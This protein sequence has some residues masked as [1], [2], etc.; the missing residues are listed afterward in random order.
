MAVMGMVIYLRPLR[1]NFFE[2]TDRAKLFSRRGEVLA[3]EKKAILESIEEGVLTCD[4]EGRITYLNSHAQTLLKLQNTS[5]LSKKLDEVAASVESQLF[6]EMQRL[7][8]RA[9]AEGERTRSLIALEKDGKVSLEMLAVPYAEGHGTCIVLRDRSNQKRMVE[10]G[11]EFIANA[12]HELRTP[13][14]IIRGFAETLQDLQEISEEMFNSILGKIIRNCE[15]MEILVKNLLTLA[16]L[17]ASSSLSMKECDLLSVVGSACYT[18]LNL[19]PKTHI[20]QLQ[21]VDEAPILADGS[22]LELA[23]FNLLKNAVKYSPPPAQIKITILAS[24]E[25]VEV[26]IEDQG[27]GIPE[28]EVSKIFDRFY[29]VDKSHSRQLGGA[30]LGLSIVKTIIDKHDGKIWAT[31]NIGIGTT[32]HILLPRI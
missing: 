8:Q 30:G 32:F 14:T 12:S 27:M 20:E 15:R 5:I 29:T 10:M 31:S 9:K 13:I 3:A 28:E 16:D 2:M 11:K 25:V 4:R 1:K 24:E 19:A 17:D 23:I 7:F 21:N 6:F 26:Q 18:M 22:M